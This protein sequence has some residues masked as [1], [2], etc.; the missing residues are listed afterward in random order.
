MSALKVTR[1]LVRSFR[2]PHSKEAAAHVRKGGHAIFWEKKK[3]G[4]RAAWLV[5]PPVP[6]NDLSN[7]GHWSLLDLSKW[8][9]SRPKDGVF[10]GL[11]RSRVPN[12]CFDVVT[13]RAERDSIWPGTTR[14]TAFDCLDCGACC[15]SNR[16]E[17]EKDDMKRFVKGGRADLLKPPYAKKSRGKVVLTLLASG[18]C[19][20]LAKNNACG[21]YELRP[22]A[23]SDFP[24]AS[25]CCLSAREEELSVYD[26]LPP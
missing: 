5:V 1:P 11:F 19:R 25:E 21:I 14:A 9:F 12:D 15:R 22:S 3:D 23:C 18:D 10:R 8:R 16:V 26:G 13:R 7:L 6:E 17:L 20:H 24:V 4:R 2:S